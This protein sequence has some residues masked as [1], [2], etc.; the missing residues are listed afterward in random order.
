MVSEKDKDLM[1]SMAL[2]LAYWYITNNI[3]IIPLWFLEY[4]V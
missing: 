2:P 3:S 4:H 1:S